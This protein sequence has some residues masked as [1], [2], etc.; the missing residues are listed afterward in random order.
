MKQNY[1]TGLA[2]VLCAL[3]ISAS[4]QLSSN[5]DK[6][7][8][9]ITT[10]GNNVDYN[11]VIFS[12]LWN[13]ITPENETKWSSVQGG[14]A[15]Q[16]NWGGADK[17][18]NY[19]T[20]KGL[21]FKFHCFAWG[22]QYPSW[23]EK[24]TPA[25]RY[26][27]F[28][29][30]MDGA[31]KQYPNL[32]VID[33]VNEAI[34]GHQAGTKY[35]EEA[36][37]GK[38]KTGYDW[39]V[40]AFKLAAERW[41]NAIL[42]YNDFNTFRWQKKEYIDLV[43]T[44]RDAGAPIDAYGMQSHDLTDMEF[45]EFKA[46]M[47]E[48][49]DSLLMPMYSTEYDIGTGD[50]ALQL[51]RYQA[52]IPYMWEKDYFAGLTLWGFVYGKTWTTDGNSGIIKNPSK[53]VYTE[54][55]AFTWLKEYM[56]TDA[57]K[58]AKSPF[59]AYKKEASIY[60][61]PKAIRMPIDEVVPV[62]V[63]AHLNN[64]KTIKSV[65]LYANGS[66][67]ET[68]TSAP[69]EFSYQPEKLGYVRL[70][71]VVTDTEDREYTRVGGVNIHKPRK[72]FGGVATVLPGTLEL[73]NFDE[74]GESVAYHD[75]D[76]TNSGSK[77]D[78]RTG[79]GVDLKEENDGVVVMSAVKGEW[80]EYTVDVKEEG[81]YEYDFIVKT[82]ASLAQISLLLAD[83]GLENLCTIVPYNAEFKGKYQSIKGRFAKEL[84]AG[85]HILRVAID[86]SGAYIDKINFKHININKDLITNIETDVKK[87]VM[88][89]TV[90]V[91]VQTSVSSTA[92]D[93]KVAKVDVYVGDKLEITSDKVPFSFS[94]KTEEL[95]T[96]VVKA[97]AFDNNGYEAPEATAEVVVKGQRKPYK[98]KNIPGTIEIENFD[99]AGEG[100]SFHDSD[101]TDEGGAKYRTDNE[102]VDIIK[103][104]NGGYAV[105]YTAAGEWLEYTVNVTKAGEYD[106][107]I[108]AATGSSTSSFQLGMKD[109]SDKVVNISNNI[110]IP[111]LKESDWNQYT[112]IKGSLTKE[113]KEG[114]QVIRLTIVNDYCNI[115]K[116]RLFL[117]GTTPEPDDDDAIVEVVSNDICIYNVYTTAGILVGQMTANIENIKEELAKLVGGKGLFIVKN[118]ENGAAKLMSTF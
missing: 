98:A 70:K 20:E 9:N 41:P 14:S 48:I 55:P 99:I 57:A 18:N 24:L 52:Q 33:V 101:A 78:Y 38:G 54:R 31:K 117:K 73:E 90:N 80:L 118:T 88:D 49:Q 81:I 61:A 58:T 103:L 46:A 112:T 32:A 23:I 37:G 105:G 96:C 89:G 29:N 94:F 11:G 12:D 17:C 69:Y 97:I 28:I 25:D 102:G 4:A 64:G 87:V 6:F 42:I 59:P 95:G 43:K 15:T 67:V 85:K 83:D 82:S 93:I 30:W 2:A 111:M 110:A 75:S 26:A 79:I 7:L 19:A 60:I 62:T 72:P 21:L 51:K 56:A 50:D 34:E 92:T 45:D 66:L 106:Y 116:I 100:Q 86:A 44:L 108:V 115:D 63:N 77:L 16:W 91:S 35:F 8:G 47:D 107:E 109:D 84:T 13:Q 36:L 68:A 113:L 22:S 65:A 53:G 1:K 5:P 27:A 74:G 76:T 40:N 71:A 104:D 3:S 114:E 10:G 39:I